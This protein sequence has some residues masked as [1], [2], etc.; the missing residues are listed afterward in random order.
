MPRRKPGSK[1]VTI[2]DV[3]RESGF[4]PS[5]VSIV[6]NEAPLSERI[7]AGTKERI[8]KTAE[9]LGYRPNASARLLRTHRSQTIGVMI[10]DLSDPFCTLILRGI[11]TS[12]QPT[13]YLP[14]MMNANNNSKQLGA[15]LDLLMERRVEGLIVVANWLFEAEGLQAQLR[16]RHL[17]TIVVGRDLSEDTIRSVVVD[18]R[19]GGFIAMQHLYELGHR[20]IAC[21][22]GPAKLGDSRL[23]WEGIRA[24]CAEHDMRI[25]RELVR[26]LPASMDP[27]S[28]FDGGLTLTEQLLHSGVE[29]TALVAFD[30]LTAL[31]AVR[32]LS[33]AGRSVPTDCS[34]VGFD[35]VPPAWFSTPDLTT[36]RQPMEAMGKSAAD[37]V[38]N[39]LQPA[40]RPAGEKGLAEM[41]LLSMA[42]P[43]LVE[44]GS[45]R[46]L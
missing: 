2:I 11:E 33:R 17:P 29:F 39:E 26:Q 32:A 23:R 19:R 41:P 18:N 36:V 6:L 35:D 37:W 38:L 5:T 8:R 22:R 46:A 45:T 30:D 20:K 21:L 13:S 15:Y 12:L 42:P 40:K 44:R 14:I 1:F 10:F 43:V 4:S 9:L 25:P 27:N 24:F 3:A 34:V 31:G 16:N 28:E 7:A